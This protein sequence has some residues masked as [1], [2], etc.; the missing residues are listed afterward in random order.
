M[1]LVH[2][3]ASKYTKAWDHLHH[4]CSIILT[5][6]MVQSPSWEAN[7]FAASKEIPHISW[8]PKVHYRTN[9]CPSP[10]SILGQPNP[11]TYPHPTSWRSILILS[12]H[13]R[14]GL[15][16]RLFPSGFPTKTLYA[17]IS[18]PIHATC[19]AHL[20]LLDFITRTIL[21][22]EYRSLSSSLCSLL[23]SPVTSSLLGPN[24]LL[25]TIF[26]NTLSFLSSRNVSDQASHSYKTTGKI[27]VL[28]ILIFNFL[29]SNMEDKRFC[30]EW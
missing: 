22:E 13:L 7:W 1:C 3:N 26:S 5:Y 10:V 18:S 23:H 19:P 4:Y 25:N 17:P 8:N 2:G 14:L 6:S 29:D 20:I 30:T 9:K 15:P 11:V 21:G 24:I 28:Y 16:S 12:T 27:I